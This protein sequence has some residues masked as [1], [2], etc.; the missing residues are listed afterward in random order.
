MKNSHPG[1]HCRCGSCR[2]NHSR[3][4]RRQ[5]AEKLRAA[6]DVLDMLDPPDA[7]TLRTAAYLRNVADELTAPAG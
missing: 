6:A 2:A 7:G 5:Q 1:P 4:E 3:A